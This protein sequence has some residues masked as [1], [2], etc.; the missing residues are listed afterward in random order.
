M[1][2]L[3]DVVDAYDAARALGQSRA[4]ALFGAIG[5][6]VARHPDVSVSDAGNEVVRLLRQA[7][8]MT[9]SGKGAIAY[10][11]AQAASRSQETSNARGM[12]R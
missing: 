11:T 3:A 9:A 1:D 10:A 6:Y 4:E 5:V 7:A 8:E 12:D 2:L